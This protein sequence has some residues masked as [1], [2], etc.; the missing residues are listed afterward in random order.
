MKRYPD[1][2]ENIDSGFGPFG[3]YPLQGDMR[4]GTMVYVCCRSSFDGDD[5]WRRAELLNIGKITAV[6]R[7]FDD[8]R[9]GLPPVGAC[10]VVIAS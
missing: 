9:V 7:F 4:V 6:V 10:R 1:V 8:G 2:L 5:Y 3:T